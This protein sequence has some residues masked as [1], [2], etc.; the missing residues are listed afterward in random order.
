MTS[1]VKRAAE[2]ADRM[3]AELNQQRV[4]A[5]QG[6]QG[7]PPV[8]NQPEIPDAVAATQTD[9]VSTQ[10]DVGVQTT[11][12]PAVDET[13]LAALRKEV[14][15]AN[16]RWRVLQG[17]IDKKDSEV[18]NMRALLVQLSQ[19]AE[20]PKTETQSQLVTDRDAEAFGD[21]H[22]DL[23][24]R[25]AAEVFDS[26]IRAVMDKIARLEQSITGVG[27][28]TAKTSAEV[29]DDALTRQVPNWRQVNVDPAFIAWLQEEEGFTGKTKLDLLTDAY[30]KGD[31]NRT[32]RFFKAYEAATGAPAH[33]ASVASAK[34]NVTKLI[35]PGKSRS[36]ATPLVQGNNAQIWTKDDISRL[37]DDKRNG[38]INQEEFDKYE[39]D[40]FRSI[41]QGEIKWHIQ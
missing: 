37:Y 1:N 25:I 23:G 32:A 33:I 13:A 36:A 5:E 6:A 27:E 26:R 14:E 31:L 9:E 11:N 39:R 28:M 21:D 20:T 15:T 30:S 35:A 34:D 18:E 19:K 22:V 10:T 38:R 12:T 24:R 40:L 29:F 7:E 2:E 4:A 41:K 16:Q 17:M 3:I 8:E